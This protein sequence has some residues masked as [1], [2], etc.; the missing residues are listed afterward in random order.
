MCGVAL[1]LISFLSACSGTPPDSIGVHNGHLTPCPESPN[2]VSSFAKDS[3]HRIDPLQF[4]GNPGTVM[5]EL[6]I[7]L[8]SLDRVKIVTLEDNYVYAEFTS[9]LMRYVDD[10]EFLLVAEDRVL[11]FRSASRIGYGDLGVNRKRI[12]S[13]RQHLKSKFQ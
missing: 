2:C 6:K 7:H 5:Q 9:L 11:H 13:I 8:S 3:E 4:S 10:V 1:L 12:E